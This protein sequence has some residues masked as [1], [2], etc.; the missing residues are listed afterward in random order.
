MYRDEEVVAD[1]EVALVFDPESLRPL[2]EP[3][4]NV[5]CAVQ[6]GVEARRIASD[7]AQTVIEAAQTLPYPARTYRR[8]LKDAGSVLGADL[9]GLEPLLTSH[10]QKRLDALLLFGE[11]IGRGR[12]ESA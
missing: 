2:S 8:I 4:V 3:L 10:D 9:S 5:R 1:D 7:Q 11:L 6:H 12:R